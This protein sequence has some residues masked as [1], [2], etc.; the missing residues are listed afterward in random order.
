LLEHHHCGSHRAGKIPPAINGT[1]FSHNE[2][3]PS[4]L[5]FTLQETKD[6]FKMAQD[7]RN[8]NVDDDVVQNIHGITAGYE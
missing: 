5:A 8:M 4:A 1:A 6:L 2:I 7:D 3:P